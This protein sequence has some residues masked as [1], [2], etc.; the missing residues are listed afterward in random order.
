[1]IRSAITAFIIYLFAAGCGANGHFT[2]DDFVAHTDDET[3]AIERIRH[4]VGEAEALIDEP[5]TQPEHIDQL[6]AAIA[7]VRSALSDYNGKR[8]RGS[9]RAVI[10][11][12]IR[13]SAA[14][15]VADDAT[16]VGVGNDVALVPLALVAVATYVITDARASQQELT[17]AWNH[18]LTTTGALGQTVKDIVA[19]TSRGNVADTGIMAE[20]N[21]LIAA[22]LAD[23]ICH[24]LQK[25]MNGLPKGRLSTQQKQR[26]RKIKR[27]QKANNCRGHR[28]RD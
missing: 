4:W 1:M 16:G 5:W 28:P 3:E 23:N 24:A 18:V 15:I 19:A 17:R 11:A 26:K 22:D 6:R 14:A 13:A 2:E 10:I 27:T 9:T 20:V 21:A 12:P 25:L 8:E 7:S